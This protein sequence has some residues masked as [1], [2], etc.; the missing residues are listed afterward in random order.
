M[1]IFHTHIAAADARPKISRLQRL[2]ARD[3]ELVARVDRRQPE[4]ELVGKVVA[5]A[6][7]AVALNE[8]RRAEVLEARAGTRQRL[9]AALRS[10]A[11]VLKEEYG[12]C[13]NF[14]ITM[15]LDLLTVLVESLFQ[16]FIVCLIFR[17]YDYDMHVEGLLPANLCLATLVILYCTV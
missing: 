3:A 5:R 14:I 4:A 2:R 13:Y 16:V 7:C 9:A 11:R 6:T 8:R 17:S 15:R 10:S 12:E 1:Y